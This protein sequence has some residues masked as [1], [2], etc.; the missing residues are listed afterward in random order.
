MASSAVLTVPQFLEP[1]AL[2]M[3]DLHS[4]AGLPPDHQSL[5]DGR[6]ETLALVSQVSAVE[7]AGLCRGSGQFDQILS[8]SVA[9]GLVDES[10]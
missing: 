6:H 4:G 8:R 10:R 3:R 7:P 5:L 9:A 2:K 1:I